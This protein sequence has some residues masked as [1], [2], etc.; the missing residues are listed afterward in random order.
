[1]ETTDARPTR[2]RPP[3]HV[4]DVGENKKDYYHSVLDK[5]IDEFLIIPASD[6]DE[7]GSSEDNED[8][9]VRN[10]SMCLLKY[11]FVYADLKDA[12]KEGNGKR[13]GT[14]HKQ[15]LPLFKSMPGFN[16]Y[17]VEMFINILQNEVLL[18]E[19]ESHQCIWAATANWKGGQGKN[20]EIDIL[21]ENRNKDIKKEIWGMGA[22]KTDKAIDRASRAAGGQRK[23]VENFEQ[24]VGRG[25]Q[26]SSHSH[27]SS[28][29]DESKVCRDLRD[30]KPFSFAPNRKHDSFPDI[31]ADPWPTVNEEFK[32]WV[33][34]H[35]NLLL[36]APIG[37]EDEE[38][39]Q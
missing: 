37:Q 21:Q 5:F 11:F 10:Y 1:M 22:N 20:I 17:A 23:I 35:K 6:C 39:E 13:L 14:L 33:A 19:A 27:K 32:K 29:T 28:A 3:Y 4:L 24:Q 30:L 7:E 18:S 34:R 2:N 25:V 26:H 38:D 36:N 8:D 15:L 12:V 9:F 31:M 16:A